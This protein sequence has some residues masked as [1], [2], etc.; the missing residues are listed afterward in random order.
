MPIQ[1]CPILQKWLNEEVTFHCKDRKALFKLSN[2][3]GYK[4]ATSKCKSLHGVDPWWEPST[5]PECGQDLMETLSPSK[6]I[7]YQIQLP[8]L[9]I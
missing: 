1:N 8:R 6:Y 4:I 3:T 7:D 2:T 5:F 9:I